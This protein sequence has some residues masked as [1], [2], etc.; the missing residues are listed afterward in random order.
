MVYEVACVPDGFNQAHQF[1]DRSVPRMAEQWACDALAVA[2]A[3]A[4]VSYVGP[5]AAPRAAVASFR[6][7][8]IP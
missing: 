2:S 8:V 6:E 7:P 4:G 5:T 3:T 1:I